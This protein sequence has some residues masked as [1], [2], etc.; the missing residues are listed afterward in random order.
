MLGNLIFFP[1]SEIF[2]QLIE[3]FICFLCILYTYLLF[4][5]LSYDLR[6]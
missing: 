6:F 2:I 3:K 5:K 1:L 4:I